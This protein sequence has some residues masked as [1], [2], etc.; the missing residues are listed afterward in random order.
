[1]SRELKFRAWDKNN[2][3]WIYGELLK[4]IFSPKYKHDFLERTPI[5]EEWS[6]YTGLKDK[7]GKD[8]Y[9]GDIIKNILWSK[10]FSSSAKQC[11]VIYEVVWYD[12]GQVKKGTKE[13]ELN[14]DVLEEDPSSFTGEPCFKGRQIKNEKGYGNGHGSCFSRCEII[15]NIYENPELIK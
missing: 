11:E 15:G 4:G 1:M 12:G 8:I 14:K 6:Q 13:W 10:P 9:E 2:K 5:W 7:N 3:Q